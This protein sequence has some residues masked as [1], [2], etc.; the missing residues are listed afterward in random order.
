MLTDRGQRKVVP[1]ET[2][3]TDSMPVY[4]CGFGR[5]R[6]HLVQRLANPIAFMVVLSMYG[7]MEGAIASGETIATCSVCMFKARHVATSTDIRS[8]IAS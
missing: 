5:C 4:G 7:V 2:K 1:S 6:P 3:E 8:H